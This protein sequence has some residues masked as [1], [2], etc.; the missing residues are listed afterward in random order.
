[1]ARAVAKRI[2]AFVAL[3]ISFF[4]MQALAQE[5]IINIPHIA[6]TSDL[7]S[8]ALVAMPTTRMLGKETA[9]KALAK[10]LSGASVRAA[11]TLTTGKR[12]PADLQ[13][14]GGPVLS[15]TV[16][17]AIFVNPTS[18][19]P[20][21][22]C[23]GDPIGFLTDLNRS[24][25]IRLTDQYVGSNG[26]NRFPVGDNYYVSGYTP[27]YGGTQ[28][29]NLD[30]ALISYGVASQTG[31]FGYGHMYQVFLV[32]GQDL[33]FDNTY[34]TCY[35]PD[36]PNTWYFCAY[37]SSASD[38]SGN[39]VVYSAEPYQ[40]VDGCSVRPDTPN[41]Q[42][43]D[44]TNSVL[45]HEV[46]EAITDPRGSAW[47]ISADNG[48]YG[49]EIGDECSFLDFTPTNVYFDPN[50]VRLNGKDYAIQPEYSN[51]QHTCTT[52]PSD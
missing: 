9:Q 7:Q 52:T 26:P 18:A 1:M 27:V 16:H 19:C 21:N 17:H 8:D 31:Q 49:E 15:S 48:I 28:L 33:C 32:P 38:S 36:V 37:H 29:T 40:N 20:P 47:W 42:L 41:G 13:Y 11:S 51:S 30:I 12:Y 2:A 43:A 45:S 46:F 39:R 4:C 34:S 44:S 50:F 3:S 6:F 35:S 10:H 14:H 5:K 25:M 22:T 24:A 23:W